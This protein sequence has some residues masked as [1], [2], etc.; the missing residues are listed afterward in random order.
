[1]LSLQATLLSQECSYC[2]QIKLVQGLWKSVDLFSETNL[3]SSKLA[4]SPLLWQLRSNSSDCYKMRMM[5][6]RKNMKK[7]DLCE[8]PTQG[9]EFT[10][11]CS[12]VKRSERTV[13]TELH[14]CLFKEQADNLLEHENCAEWLN[15]ERHLHHLSQAGWICSPHILPRSCSHHPLQTLNTI[16]CLKLGVLMLSA[17]LKTQ[18]QQGCFRPSDLEDSSSKAQDWQ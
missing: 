14:G 2:R 15:S 3:L 5:H 17:P 16:P 4:E 1:M 18:K 7:V 11:Q 9:I 13:F 6:Q 8:L 10:E 12:V